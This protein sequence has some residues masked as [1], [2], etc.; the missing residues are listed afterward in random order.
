MAKETKEE[1]FKRLG[2]SGSYPSPVEKVFSER[3]IAQTNR[4]MKEE[5]L[6][7]T[8]N[9][10]FFD[11]IGQRQ[12]TQGTFFEA[13][14]Q[15]KAMNL[16][17]EEGIILTPEI[18]DKLTGDFDNI[19]AIENILEAAS[20]HGLTYA[21]FL[22]NQYRTSDK[23]KENLADAGMRG[24][25]AMIVSDVLDPADAAIMAA[26]ATAVAAASPATAPITAPLAALGVKGA[27]LY[28]RFK[29]NKKFLATAFGVG[30]AE[31][32]ALE[33]L[34]KQSDYEISGGD[35]ALA[36]GISG[37]ANS[38]FMKAAQ[39]FSR[40][41]YKQNILAK[42]ANDEKLNPTEQ[43]FFDA[44]TPDQIQTKFVGD[45]IAGDDFK[46]LETGE[47]SLLDAPL[48]NRETFEQDTRTLSQVT[49]EEAP[50]EMRG[51]MLT[52]RG[53]IASMPLIMNSA[54]A[55]ARVL[56]SK[57][58]LISTGLKGRATPFSA[59]ELRDAFQAQV[60]G[61]VANPI[62][63]IQNEFKKDVTDNLDVLHE[64]ASRY[65]RF[66]DTN[67]HPLA[68]ALGDVLRPEMD[69]MLRKAQD[70][71]AV[72][73]FKDADMALD[74]YLPRFRSEQAIR[75]LQAK[76]GKDAD[77]FDELAEKAIREGQP[78]IE[79]DIAKK[80]KDAGKLHS[81]EHVNAFISRLARGYIRKF[82][83]L[84][85]K[86]GLRFGNN[87]VDVEQ[88]G[89]FLKVAEFDDA[90]I[91][92]IK[93][94]LLQNKKTKSH[95]RAQMRMKLNESAT[96]TKIVD[97]EEFVISF[98]DLLEQNV[99]SIFEG[100]TFQ[101]SGAIA[102][103]RNGINTNEV[104][105][106]FQDQL[107][108]VRKSGKATDNEIKALEFLYDV[109]VGTHMY[110]SDMSMTTI[111]NL[112]R[113][114]EFSFAVSMGMS[115]LSALMELPMVT[116][117]YGF[118]VLRKTVPQFN[119]L[120]R[121]MKKGGEI[122]NKLG[123]EIAAATGV[124][125]DGLT[126][127]VTPL[128]SRYEGDM[129]GIELEGAR[130][131]L[132]ERLGQGRVF[133][134]LMSGLTGVTD[135][136]RRIA[137]FNYANA[138][139]IAI[140]KGKLPFTKVHMEQLGISDEMA[141]DM[142]E[143]IVKHRTREDGVLV[144]LNLDKW[145]RQDLADLFSLSARR[146]ATQAVQEMN[147]GS[148]NR[149]LRSPVGMTVFQFLSY[150]MASMEQQAMRLGV[151]AANGEAM[152]VA[153]LITAASFF[154]AMIYTGRIYANAAGRSEES[155]QQ[156]YDKL[157]TWP[158]IIGGGISQVGP[159]SLGSY[160]YQVSNGLI[161]GNTRGITPAALSLTMGVTKGAGDIFETLTGDEMTESELRGLLRTLPLSSLYGARQILN[162]IANGMTDN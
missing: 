70:A 53:F 40:Q 23:V 82:M 100:L 107:N 41:A 64:Q 154:G 37:A 44:N 48:P 122:R 137:V 126:M 119:T 84:D 72:G 51:G 99:I 66:G 78:N 109:T 59:T 96:I 83:D 133:V 69:E 86:D 90:D 75:T 151:R 10:G 13:L 116:L 142:V 42:I 80:L 103:A 67:V 130:T 22:A 3:E 5:G 76:F 120:F 65:L 39:V 88:F 20:K 36:V 50:L 128:K 161:D 104:G 106:A 158:N 81:A 135:M 43:A 146:E 148:V 112:N 114:R 125:S 108:I 143:Q 160:I 138:W 30:G 17:K 32:G 152:E 4:L 19:N 102:L 45:A 26:T 132:D 155:K 61:R 85:S 93:D 38:G 157:L 34:R 21:N 141:A 87:D 98:N 127:K 118:D 136:L 49:D 115:G 7:R 33:Y 77:I 12:A 149:H 60:R 56:G 129:E 117:P 16:E 139:D 25:T 140:E 73:F 8:E 147:A 62:R 57:L 15:V 123:R 101:M 144:A 134:S 110:R 58:G 71:N 105:S 92:I 9:M 113:M 150:P 35:I 95:K 156:Y 162:G 97:G 68:K 11:L 6:K 28:G 1:V 91:D 63:R 18:A 145:D 47:D 29:N 121:D 54:D 55:K 124:G 2:F 52:L 153:K 111:R 31:A 14:D 94:I 89:E 74:N 131:K 79:A 46:V 24:G 27:K 159:L